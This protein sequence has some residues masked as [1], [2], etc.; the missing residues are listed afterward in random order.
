MDPEKLYRLKTAQ[1][2]R[3]S[4]ANAGKVILY[5]SMFST[6]LMT[7]E[8]LTSFAILICR[9][10]P[11][12]KSKAGLTSYLVSQFIASLQT[13]P[14]ITLTWNPLEEPLTGMSSFHIE[15]MRQDARPPSTYAPRSRHPH[16]TF[17][18]GSHRSPERL[19]RSLLE[20][21]KLDR[22]IL[23]VSFLY[24]SCSR[25]IPGASRRTS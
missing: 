21:V 19:T 25:K 3:T 14:R 24:F 1:P 22:I 6:F 11:L 15:T 8:E 9:A 18:L 20:E 16:D 10:K 4:Y 2:R 7:R 17:V 23:Y 5:G 12:H 13:L